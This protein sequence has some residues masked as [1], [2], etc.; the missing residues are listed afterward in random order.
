MSPDDVIDRIQRL[1]PWVDD[2]ENDSVR[3]IALE[4]CGTFVD[5]TLL[6]AYVRLYRY[7]P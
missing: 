3:E 4:T 2:S 7:Y 6:Y 1:L 5:A